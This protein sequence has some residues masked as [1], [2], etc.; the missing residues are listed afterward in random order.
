MSAPYQTQ[1]IARPREGAKR[2]PM[3]VVGR[4]SCKGHEQERNAKSLP[5]LPAASAWWGKPHLTANKR[6]VQFTAPT[7][8]E[9]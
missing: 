6:K 7:G 8:G 1:G 4:C 9:I 2:P 3:G 5:H